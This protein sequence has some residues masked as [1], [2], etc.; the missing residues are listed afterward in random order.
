MIS[1]VHLYLNNALYVN[2]QMRCYLEFAPLILLNA[3]ATLAF[4]SD[5]SSF[6]SMMA[7]SPNLAEFI[8]G[9][10]DADR[11]QWASLTPTRRR[12]AE[13]RFEVFEA[14]N[15][16]TIDAQNAIQRIGKSPSRFYRLAAE[17]REKPSLDALGVGI[18]APRKREKLDPAVVN[19]LQ[20]KVGEIV[21]L[22]ADLSVARQAR[23]LMDA[24]GFANGKPIGLTTLRKIVEDERRR[25]DA[26][27]RLGYQIGLDCSAINLPQPNGRPY[28]LY[29]IVDSGTGI[30]LGYSV[31]ATVDVVSGYA[32]AAQSALQWILREGANL[33]WAAH[34]VQTV[35]VSGEDDAS[36]RQLVEGLQSVGLGGNVL[37]AI[38]RRRFGSQFRRAY[39]ERLGRI[40]ITPARTLEGHALPDNG[41]MTPWPEAEARFELERTFADHNSSVI[42]R[43][44]HR[45]GSSPPESLLELLKKLKDGL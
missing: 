28:I 41:N 11:E 34:L 43:L 10:S 14:W 26:T 13:T 25:V 24:A 12:E 18:R 9:L 30:A 33:P 15:A 1:L 20:A 17:W 2:R 38:S 29:V 45:E 5:F 8:A 21:R 3:A 4:P 7:S 42:D 37:R 40:Q 23:L 36:S 22:Y 35:I 27:G 32:A 44:E 16:G 31:S 39:G 6:F 19:R